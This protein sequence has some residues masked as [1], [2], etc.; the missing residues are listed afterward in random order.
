MTNMKQM[1]GMLLILVVIAIILMGA[2]VLLPAYMEEQEKPLQT[3][4]TLT[5]QHQ[6]TCSSPE[7]G[8]RIMNSQI[9]GNQLEI[10]LENQGSAIISRFR[11]IIDGE[12]Y[13]ET[14][15]VRQT[16]D[17]F[18]IKTIYADKPFTMGDV[19]KITMYPMLTSTNACM[20]KERVYELS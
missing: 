16:L 17:S 2:K 20:N 1:V 15:E 10:E 13:D 8:F 7:L 19:N 3:E 9:I 5:A 12:E 11:I 6:I 4:R 14:V 18:S